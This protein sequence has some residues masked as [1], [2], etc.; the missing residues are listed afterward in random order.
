MAPKTLCES[1]ANNHEAELCDKLSSHRI[2][3]GILCSSP[4]RRHALQTDGRIA[5]L[6]IPFNRLF[7][8]AEGELTIV[9]IVE[10]SQPHHWRN[11]CFDVIGTAFMS[12]VPALSAAI[13]LKL[14]S[15]AFEWRG[16]VTNGEVAIF[17]VGLLS[18]S[19]LLTAKELKAPFA[20][21]QLFALLGLGG[22]ILAMASYAGFCVAAA[23]NQSDVTAG[24]ADGALTLGLL[25]SAVLYFYTLIFSAA[26]ALVDE[27]RSD[28]PATLAK[29]ATK[30]LGSNDA[31][32]KK[33]RDLGEDEDDAK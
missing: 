5:A 21:R 11:V 15:F 32:L 14:A 2:P 25:L 31:L 29:E 33:F 4:R 23:K 8:Y 30:A 19:L 1:I 16:F 20:H 24:T 6:G 12:L 10:H 26:V 22:V 17:C 28:L 3:F 9:K 7:K 18:S 27:V 13:V